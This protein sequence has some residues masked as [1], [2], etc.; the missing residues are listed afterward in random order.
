MGECSFNENVKVL[1]KAMF[2]DSQIAAK[3][4]CGERKTAYLCV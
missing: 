2:P 4:S 3:I 1:F